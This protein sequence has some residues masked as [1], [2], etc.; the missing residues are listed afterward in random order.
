V[1]HRIRR[2]KV[3]DSLFRSE[4]KKITLNNPIEKQLNF[5]SFFLPTGFLIQTQEKKNL[6]S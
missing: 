6:A 3:F 2:L 1:A 4:K 5:A